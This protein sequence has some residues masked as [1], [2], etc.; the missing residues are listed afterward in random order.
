MLWPSHFIL[1]GAISGCPPVFPSSILSTFL[2]LNLI[3]QYHIFLHFHTGN[4]VLKAKRREWFAISFCITVDFDLSILGGSA[5]HGSA[6]HWIMQVPS[7]WQS[8]S[9]VIDLP[10]QKGLC[11]SGPLSHAVQGHPRQTGHSKQFWWN[12]FHW[13]RKWQIAPVFLPWELHENY[14]QIQDSYVLWRQ[15]RGKVDFINNKLFFVFI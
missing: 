11:N 13:R 1:S 2:P 15:T 9:Q 8:P 7:P 3:F 5:T 4:G 14:V 6:L 12:I 10:W